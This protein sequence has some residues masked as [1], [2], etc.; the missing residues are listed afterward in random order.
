MHTYFKG[1]CD[2]YEAMHASFAV[3]VG[4]VH[5]MLRYNHVMHLIDLFV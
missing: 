2:V 4:H 5:A 1:L 3:Y